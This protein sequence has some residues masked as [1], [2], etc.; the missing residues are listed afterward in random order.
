MTMKKTAIILSVFLLELGAYSASAQPVN[1]LK[2]NEIVVHNEDGL[3]DDW[4]KRSGWVEIFNS[5]YATVNIG[6][7]Y[8]T[9]DVSQPKMYPIPKGDVLTVIAP[10]QHTLFWAD[11]KPLRGTFHVNF[12]LDSVKYIAL[13]STDGRTLIDSVA[14]PQNMP[15]D[16]SYGRIIDGSSTWAIFE[17]TTPSTNNALLDSNA[18]NQRFEKYDP[19]GTAMTITA[20]SVVFIVLIL[21]Y[22]FFRALGKTATRMSAAKVEVTTGGAKGAA[23][24]EMYAAI[25]FAMHQYQVD[26]SIVESNVLTINKVAKA[27]SPWSSKIYGLRQAPDRKK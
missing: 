22:L 2:I 4:G 25:A 23:S 16:K 18:A 17:K 7:C 26:L 1:A 21:L 6:G 10:R 15:V 13:F 12:T 3:M 8:L 20:M 11:G 19:I 27:Y 9:T 5:S 14:T 24:G